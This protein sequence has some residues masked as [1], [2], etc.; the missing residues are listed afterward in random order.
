MEW[1]RDSIRKNAGIV[2]KVLNNTR[3]S[4][5]ELQKQTGIEPLE[6]ASAIGWLAKEERI[7]IYSNEG[8][9]YFEIYQVPY[10]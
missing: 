9:L 8:V 3:L 10:F 6:L 5:E 4:W 7:N 1:S 2:C